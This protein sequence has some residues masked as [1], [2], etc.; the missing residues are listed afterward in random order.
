MTKFHIVVGGGIAGI[1]ASYFLAAKGKK[2]ILIESSDKLGGLLTSKCINGNYYDHGTHLLRETG[3]AQLDEFLHNGLDYDRF[4][5]IKAG[6]YYKRLYEKNAFLTD[7]SLPENLR[8]ECLQQL[9]ESAQKASPSKFDNLEHQLVSLFGNGYYKN[10]FRGIIKKLYFEEPANLAPD[11]HY[12]MGLSRIIASTEQKSKDLK[13]DTQVDKVLA[14]HSVQDGQ[15]SLK[16]LYPKGKGGVGVW[17]DLLEKK[18]IE[19]GVRIFKKVKPAFKLANNAT[20]NQVTLNNQDF[21]VEHLYWTVPP[22]FLYNQTNL[23]KPTVSIP[24][25]L[26]T[27][28]IDL[29]YRGNYNTDLHYFQNYD[30]SF[31]TFRVTLYDNFNN[32]YSTSGVNRITVEFLVENEQFETDKYKYVAIKELVMMGIANNESELTVV[33]DSAIRGGFPVPT[34]NF[35]K[36]SELLIDGL[37]VIDNLTLFGKATGKVWFMRDVIAEVYNKVN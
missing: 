27:V 14:F 2:V 34:P 32:L 37:S 28:I 31:K 5:Y 36:D 22:I 17:I 12:P 16:S 18:L 4:E 1:V 8:E 21:F 26:S 25:R 30:P 35:R 9:L 13:S 29:E 6:T 20:V 3:I 11:G 33:Q 23:P 24:K 7:F 15:K 19:A 10:L